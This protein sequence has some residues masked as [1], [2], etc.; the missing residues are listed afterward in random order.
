MLSQGGIGNRQDLDIVRVLDVLEEHFRDIREL[1]QGLE[2][3]IV[4]VT[5][6]A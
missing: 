3:S 4:D 1:L 5:P 6:L 2:K